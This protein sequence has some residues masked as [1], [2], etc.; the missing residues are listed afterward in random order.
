[1]KILLALAAVAIVAVLAV[2]ATM[3]AGTLVPGGDNTAEPQQKPRVGIPAK[4]KARLL[5]ISFASGAFKGVGFKSGENVT[6]KVV[7]AL[8]KATKRVKADSR[9]SFIVRL[10]LRVDQCAGMTV[11]AV[12]DKGSRTSLNFS[13]LLCVAP[14]TNK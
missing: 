1:M 6:V 11:I 9:G 12:G 10:G 5:P 13:Q 2:S 14:G 7:D 4:G 8:R 3:G